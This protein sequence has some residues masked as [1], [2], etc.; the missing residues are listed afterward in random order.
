[1]DL[2]CAQDNLRR[3]MKSY[4][5]GHPEPFDFT[6]SFTPRSAQDELRWAQRA[7]HE[8]QAG[9]GPYCRHA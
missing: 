4:K 3:A 8:S 2:A 5:S 6:R 9:R 1:M 7:Q